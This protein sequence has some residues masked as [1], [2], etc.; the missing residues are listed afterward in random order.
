MND[1]ELLAMLRTLHRELIDRANAHRCQLTEPL[2]AARGACLY[3]TMGA[4]AFSVYRVA[5]LLALRAS[6]DA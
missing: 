1:D 4:A 6:C 3:C 5:Q 2:Q